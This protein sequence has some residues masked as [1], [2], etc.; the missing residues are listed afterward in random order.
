VQPTILRNFS[1]LNLAL[2]RTDRYLKL[3]SKQ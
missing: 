3:D 1:V 2:D